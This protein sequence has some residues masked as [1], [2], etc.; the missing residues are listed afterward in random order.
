MKKVIS[1]INAIS[2]ISD[3]TIGQIDLIFK[4][5]KVKKNELFINVGDIAKKIGF[6]ETGIMRAF[7]RNDEGKEYNKHFFLHLVLLLVILL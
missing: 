7:Y 3:E 6:L 2:P 5:K 4:F 1:Y